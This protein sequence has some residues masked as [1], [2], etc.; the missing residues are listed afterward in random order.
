MAGQ[1]YGNSVVLKH[2]G[3]MWQIYDILTIVTGV[4]LKYSGS[5]R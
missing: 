3:S 5:M 2:S 4:I 1:V